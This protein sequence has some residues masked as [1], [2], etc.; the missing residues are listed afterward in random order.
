MRP[1]PTPKSPQISPFFKADAVMLAVSAQKDG[2]LRP[3]YA[4]LVDSRGG[5]LIVARGG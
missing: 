3:V 2:K 1:D 5:A 4:R